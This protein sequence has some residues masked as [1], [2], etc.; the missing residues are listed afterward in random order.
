[1][2]EPNNELDQLRAEVQRL[3][4]RNATLRQMLHE[5]MS[6]LVSMKSHVNVRIDAI[7]AAL[8]GEETK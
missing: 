1:M 4:K 3:T 5:V 2:S 8:D 6:F 7:N